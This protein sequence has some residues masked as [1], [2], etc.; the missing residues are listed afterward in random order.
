MGVKT[1]YLLVTG[2]YTRPEYDPERPSFKASTVW[3]YQE[4]NDKGRKEWVL[5]IKRETIDDAIDGVVEKIY[6][7]R[8]ASVNAYTWIGTKNRNITDDNLTVVLA[9]K[10]IGCL[11]ASKPRHRRLPPVNN[12]PLQSMYETAIKDKRH[13]AKQKKRLFQKV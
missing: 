10:L 3:L 8:A 12:L 9:R 6:Q 7:G 13:K 4:K 1:G 11:S 5:D 2:Y